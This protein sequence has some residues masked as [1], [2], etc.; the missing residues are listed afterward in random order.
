VV[1]WKANG[2]DIRIYRTDHPPLHVHVFK[3]GRLVARY[4]LEERKFMD[5]SVKR[6]EG[7][8]KK[9]LAQVGLI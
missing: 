6:H 2:Y 3:D 8:V 1:R 9:A 7:R 4:D 5:G